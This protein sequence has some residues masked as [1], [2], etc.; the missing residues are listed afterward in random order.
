VLTAKDAVADR[1]QGLDAGADDYLIKPFAFPELLARI[2]ALI[3]RGKAA[4]PTLLRC[5]DLELKW[6]VEARYGAISVSACTSGG[7]RF[8]I[9]LPNHLLENGAYGY[10]Q[11]NHVSGFAGAKP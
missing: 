4:E 10:P 8:T 11:A 1:V 9:R 2:R 5:A 7:S 3:R 6:I